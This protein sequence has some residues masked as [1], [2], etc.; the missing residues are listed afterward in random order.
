[1][2]TLLVLVSI[3]NPDGDITYN[4][5]ADAID[6]GLDSHS[7]EGYTISNHG[8]IDDEQGEI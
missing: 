1:M 2:K 4:D 3:P 6:M 7:I 8:E 5:V